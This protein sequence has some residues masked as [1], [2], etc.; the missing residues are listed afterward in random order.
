MTV[1][2][3]DTPIHRISRVEEREKLLA[4]AMAHAEAQEAQYKVIPAD[5][6]LTGLWK[7]PLALVVF[8]IAGVVGVF[9]PEWV[10]GPPIPSVQ[11]SDLERG[12]RA[13]IYLQATQVNVFRL[14]NARLPH[15]LAELPV[16]MPG[17]R[18]VNS[19][20]R[21][22][23]ILARTP[24]GELLVYDSAH[25]SPSFASTSSGWMP[26]EDQP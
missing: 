20:N 9:P 21:V 24:D 23:Q 22:F 14:R 25:P 10:A 13:A 2:D 5:D 15:D 19:N 17:L 11:S 8:L 1:D 7:T 16:R 18:L 3:Q 12:L 4:E 26:P 6:P